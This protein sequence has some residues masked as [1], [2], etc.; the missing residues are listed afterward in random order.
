MQKIIVGFL[1]LF[2]S[3]ASF[4]AEQPLQPEQKFQG[5]NL[6]GYKEDGEKSWDVNGDTADVRGSKVKLSNVDANAYGDQKMNVKA[7][8]G[9]LDQANGNMRLEKD[10]TVTSDQGTQLTTDSL[11]WNR[12][13]DIVTTD[14]DV[15]IT[16][17]RMT[18][19]GKGM[20]AHP[21]LKNAKIEKDVTVMVN[22]GQENAPLTDATKLVITSDGPMV[23]DQ[24]KSVAIFRQNV[25][26]TQVGRTLKADI[27]E[28][29]FDQ[30][31]KGVKQMICYGNVVIEQGEN[32]T[33][34]D[35]ATYDG[36]AQRLTLSG[37]PKLI[38][39]T[40]GNNGIAS[41]GNKKSN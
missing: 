5:F 26:A 38:L 28:V 4:A 9:T 20:Q 40:E 27:M 1:I 41:V 3:A 23:I 2:F 36:I 32:R 10:V 37:R 15:M 12:T 13:A 31:M 35:K 21:S 39:M 11:D 29:Y 24:A 19:T 25:L 8:T 7:Q 14:A 33:Y 6:Q 30:N 22:T 16:D 17:K 18:A 34:A